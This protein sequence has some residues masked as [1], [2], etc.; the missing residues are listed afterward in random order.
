MLSVRNIDKSFGGLQ[1]LRRVSLDVEPCSVT[2]LV[3]PNGSGKTTLFNI[4][5]GLYPKDAGEI[6]FKG[7]KIDGLSPSARAK[8]GLCRTFQV[9]KVPMKMTVLEN[10]LLA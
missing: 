10:M 5:S 8:K 2:G 6:L 3:G 7:E 9:A 1:V 4:I